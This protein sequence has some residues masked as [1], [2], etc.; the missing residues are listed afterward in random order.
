MA[1]NAS[2]AYQKAQDAGIAVFTQELET[3]KGKLTRVRAGPYTTRSEANAMAQ[4]VRALGL[5]A[6]V[7]RQ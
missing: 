4:K 1:T 2:H 7:M 3:P 6:V 5:D